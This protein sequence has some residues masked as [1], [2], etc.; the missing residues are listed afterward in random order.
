[1]TGYLV[2]GGV[3]LLGVVGMLIWALVERSR[4]LEALREADH[5]T[6][7]RLESNRIAEQ[8]AV[9]VASTK[10]EAIRV[11]QELQIVREKLKEAYDRLVRC[12]DPRAIQDWLD[13][14]LKGEE[15]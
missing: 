9:V 4:K 14:E 15:V 11:Q 13:A 7:L 2:V 3:G 8:N 1:V 10:A 12:E 5:Q 6:E